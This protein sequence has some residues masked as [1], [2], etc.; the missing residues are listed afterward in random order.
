MCYAYYC[1]ISAH[2]AIFL[3]FDAT[4]VFYIES[5]NKNDSLFTM[6]TKGNIWINN[7]K[8]LSYLSFNKF[9]Q[10]HNMTI[11]PVHFLISKCN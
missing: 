8:M 10:I 6:Y 9:K 7:V 11:F 5:F 4:I 3:I 2:N 1:N